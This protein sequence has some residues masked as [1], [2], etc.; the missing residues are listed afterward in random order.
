[1]NPNFFH[2][3]L[4]RQGGLPFSLLSLALMAV[5]LWLLRRPVAFSRTQ[6]SSPQLD[7]GVA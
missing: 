4:H 2:G 5:L 1:V 7:S 3:P 6:H